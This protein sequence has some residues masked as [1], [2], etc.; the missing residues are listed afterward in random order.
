[1]TGISR[2]PKIKIAATAVLIVLAASMFV[3]S[4]P[5]GRIL[6]GCLAA[7][8]MVLWLPWKAVKDEGPAP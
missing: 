1:M 2:V 7:L 5:L 8:A 3:I 6:S 4:V